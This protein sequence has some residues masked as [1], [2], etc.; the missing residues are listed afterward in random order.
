MLAAIAEGHTVING[1]STGADCA[2]TLACL[3]GLGVS[4]TETARNAQ[5]GV[6]LAIRGVGMEGLRA[7]AGTLDAGN[8][9]STIRMLA[10]ILAAQPFS[11][12][13]TGDA[14]LQRRPMRRVI[15]PLERMGARIASE[16]G[17]PPDRKSTRLNS[18]H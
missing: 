4:I 8:S 17:R 10:G 18:S 5:D 2:S 15:I 13:M 12:T 11:T 14:S 7:A 9:G 1:Y 3:R 6:Q 16:D